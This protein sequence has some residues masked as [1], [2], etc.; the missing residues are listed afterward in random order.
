M[1]HIFLIVLTDRMVMKEKLGMILNNVIRPWLRC[2][3]S[4]M[5]RPREEIYSTKENVERVAIDI[6]GVFLGR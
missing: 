1:N 3:F 6:R 4:S 5:L 2:Y